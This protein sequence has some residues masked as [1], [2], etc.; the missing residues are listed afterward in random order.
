VT[1]KH[2]VEGANVAEFHL[3][4]SDDD[5][6][7]LIA[8]YTQVVIDDFD[9]AWI[10]HPDQDVDL[11]LIPVSQL[12]VDADRQ[13][14]RYFYIS[15]NKELIA[16]E[17]QLEEMDA[18][19]EVVMIGYPI[20]LWDEVNNMPI[21]RR[22]ITAT[23]PK[24]NYNGY[25]EFMIDAACFPGSSGSPIFSYSIGPSVIAGGRGITMGRATPK[26]LGILYAGPQWDASGE[27]TIVTIPTKQQALINTQIPTNLGFAIKAQRLLDFE[28]ILD[29]YGSLEDY[30]ASLL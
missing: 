22:G 27:I 16:T 24:H 11:C 4:S 15:L 18:I 3:T 12:F 9:E 13:N 6:N 7:A 5:G 14:K 26:L 1:N 10:A 28:P 23:H 8:D 25:A 19:E 20:G 29:Q 2:V 17:D 21:V 30:R